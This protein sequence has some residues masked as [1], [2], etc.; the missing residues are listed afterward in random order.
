MVAINLSK[1]NVKNMNSRLRAFLR[2]GG[3]EL[4]NTNANEAVAQ[5]LGYRNWNTLAPALEGPSSPAAEQ[6]RID[7]YWPWVARAVQGERRPN[8]APQH[9]LQT[10]QRPKSDGTNT[11]CFDF[12]TMKPEPDPIGIP[13]VANAGDSEVVALLGV[14]TAAIAKIMDEYAD[15]SLE[16]A[17]ESGHETSGNMRWATLGFHMPGID[18]IALTLRAEGGAN[19]EEGKANLVAEAREVAVYLRT[20]AASMLAA[21]QA[22]G[23]PLAELVKHGRWVPYALYAAGLTL[24]EHN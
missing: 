9:L 5:M 14:F 16:V 1:D 12:V 20:R 13:I 23:R 15:G 21:W 7:L 24:S 10:W 18:R 17:S 4:K 8:G 22:S 6:A 3:I 19:Y 11:L 2:E